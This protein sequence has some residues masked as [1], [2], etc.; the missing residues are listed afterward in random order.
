VQ[1]YNAQAAV[2]PERQLIVGQSVTQ[3]AND[4]QQLMPGIEAIEEQRGQRPTAV[5]ADSGYCSEQN[6]ETSSRA[7]AVPYPKGPRASTACGAS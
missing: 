2:E 3:A 7:R 1:G 6:L 5:L 4:K